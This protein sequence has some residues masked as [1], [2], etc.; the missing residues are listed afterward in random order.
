MKSGPLKTNRSRPKNKTEAAAK[1]AAATP[2]IFS[3]NVEIKK[4]YEK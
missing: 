3:K 4:I 2:R 1:V